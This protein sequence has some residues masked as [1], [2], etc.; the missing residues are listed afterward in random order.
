MGLVNVEIDTKPGRVKDGIENINVTNTGVLL[1]KNP[2]HSGFSL[3]YNQESLMIFHGNTCFALG[4]LDEK[5][6][7]PHDHDSDKTS[8]WEEKR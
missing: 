8:L 2:L 5:S 7:K 4:P 6:T 3:G 1:F